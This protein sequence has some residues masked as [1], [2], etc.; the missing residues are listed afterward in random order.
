MVNSHVVPPESALQYLSLIPDCLLLPEV[1]RYKPLISFSGRLS[2]VILSYSIVK[3]L[4]SPFCYGS[5][6]SIYFKSAS[7]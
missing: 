5:H 6:S 1:I 3:G 7:I 4:A 2:C